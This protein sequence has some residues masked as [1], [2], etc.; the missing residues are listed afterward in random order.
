VYLRS[1][2]IVETE[3]NPWLQSTLLESVVVAL[4]GMALAVEVTRRVDTGVEVNVPVIAKVV[5]V[6]SEVVLDVEVI[7]V[8]ELQEVDEAASVKVMARVL[9]QHLWRQVAS[10]KSNRCC[11]VYFS[12]S[13]I[14]TFTLKFCYRISFGGHW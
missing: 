9:H 4:L 7:V 12:Y 11:G 8:G 10:P 13:I 14:S 6:V 1:T 3:T 5:V 2:K